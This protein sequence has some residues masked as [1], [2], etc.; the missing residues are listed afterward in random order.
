MRE[1]APPRVR[2]QRWIQPLSPMVAAVL[3]V[4]LALAPSVAH[5]VD[6]FQAPAQPSGSIQVKLY[7]TEGV[8]TGV[9]KRVT[10][11][12]PFTRGSVTP[13]DLSKIRVLKAGAEIPAYVQM[14][15]P[16]RHVSDPSIDGQ[17][18]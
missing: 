4:A 8:A 6:S 7:P 2:A 1:A 9:A 16:W 13:A 15:A 14:L 3:A 5:A 11:G 17:S 18:V 12:V 10:F